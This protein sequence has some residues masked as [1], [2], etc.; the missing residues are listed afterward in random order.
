MVKHRGHP[1]SMLRRECESVDGDMVGH[2]ISLGLITSD[3]V[4]RSPSASEVII[5][6]DNVP[7][8][9]LRGVIQ[10]VAINDRYHVYFQSLV[11]DSVHH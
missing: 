10:S 7:S 1:G 8:A 2:W 3:G 4:N 11:S 6:N 9:R 5:D